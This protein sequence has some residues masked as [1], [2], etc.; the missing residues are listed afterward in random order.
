M[1]SKKIRN[2]VSL[3]IKKEARRLFESGMPMYEVHK[4]LGINLGT[5]YNISSK[6][7]WIKG[8]LEEL[9]YTKEAEMI[10]DKLN[11]RKLERLNVYRVLTKGITDQV[12]F[13]QQEKVL[14]KFKIVKAPNEA[15]SLQA[16]T[17]QRT[18]QIEKELYGILSPLE[19]VQL[20]LNKLKY[21]KLKASLDEGI[22]DGEIEI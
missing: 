3:K 10:A 12:E 2:K 11:E 14:N 16:A 5:L 18:Y 4:Q 20:D 13:L 15:L 7:G 8:S 21:E 9:I 6:E 19:E 17:L 1:S 22:D